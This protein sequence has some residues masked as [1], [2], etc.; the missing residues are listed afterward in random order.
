MSVNVSETYF[1]N[2]KNN[3][4]TYLDL[5][6]KEKKNRSI[7]N[8]LLNDYLEVRYYNYSDEVG[9]L[10]S[11]INKY[12][13]ESS[14][15]LNDY[16]EN[17]N[18][19]NNYL[20]VFNELYLI[21]SSL[22]ENIIKTRINELDNYRK[23]KMNISDTG[24]KNELFKIMKADLNKNL[25]FINAFET[26]DFEISFDKQK[27]INVY[28][29]NL[30]HNIIFNNL[31]SNYA[32]TNAF[33]TGLVN[34]K[35]EEVL[36]YLYS[37]TA[38]RNIIKGE[39]NKNYLLEFDASIFNKRKKLNMILNIINSDPVKEFTILKISFSD[40]NNFK[41]DI[42]E[43]KRNGFNFAVIIDN[44]YEENEVNYTKLRL[45][46]YV[47]IDNEEYKYDSLLNLDNLILM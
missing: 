17:I 10:K 33:N 24:F 37:A 2:N 13:K 5:I 19:I 18:L 43:L 26:P 32:I 20:Y 28:N 9:N 36:Y 15:K 25:K 44:S 35:K 47:I 39:F 12:L 3:L 31:Y 8:K 7:Q 38:L 21:D 4:N 11:I 22:D 1:K 41:D 46:K 23:K 42:Y 14:I 6:F 16:N 34:E 45:F 30:N 27:N 29:V 40:Y